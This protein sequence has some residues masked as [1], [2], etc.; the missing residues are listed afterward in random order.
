M[1]HR[2][3]KPRLAAPAQALE[4]AAPLGLPQLM[5][6]EELST[7]LTTQRQLVVTLGEELAPRRRTEA[8]D[9]AE[10]E[11]RLKVTREGIVRA[12]ARSARSTAQ[13]PEQEVEFERLEVGLSAARAA[14]ARVLEPVLLA[15]A[16]LLVTFT[17]ALTHG[18]A[19]HW[20]VL[21]G[22]GGVALVY[23]ARGGHE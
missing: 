15:S 13:I 3:P 17:W 6:S 9:L 11:A 20:Q 10:L 21:G 22:I 14:W 4:L 16:V 2:T 12:R 19:W 1:F 5:A 18:D 7:A 8:S 23:L